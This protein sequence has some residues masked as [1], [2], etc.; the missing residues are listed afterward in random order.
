MYK[1]YNSVA[2]PGEVHLVPDSW[3][4]NENWTTLLCPVQAT[5]NLNSLPV[6]LHSRSN[7]HGGVLA[8]GI[9]EVDLPPLWSTWVP[10]PSATSDSDIRVTHIIGQRY[11][12][13]TQRYQTWVDLILI[14]VFY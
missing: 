1:Q 6:F 5:W 10:I 4:S 7:C 3:T 9:P 14:M 8:K 13:L 2:G 12:N 11:L